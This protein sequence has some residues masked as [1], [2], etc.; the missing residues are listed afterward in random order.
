MADEHASPQP[1]SG[2]ETLIPGV[3]HVIAI[4]SGKGGV[5]KSTVA[6]NLACALALTGAKVGLMDAD[7]YGPN[8]PMMMGST[9]GPEQRE[10]KI[11]PVQLAL[12]A[13]M[14]KGR[15]WRLDTLKQLGGARGVGVTF[16]EETFESTTAPLAHRV[17]E[18]ACRGVLKSLLP[19]IGAHIR[20]QAQSRPDLATARDDCRSA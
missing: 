11:V 12:F 18:K 16:L 4:S 1:P 5:G 19:P 2:K 6:A 14:C 3:K 20:G 10:G 9:S 17:H 13:D 15:P 7:L 8:I